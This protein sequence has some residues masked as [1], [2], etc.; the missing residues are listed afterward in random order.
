MCYK[1][2]YCV[3]HDEQLWQLPEA[4]QTTSITTC[5]TIIRKLYDQIKTNQTTKPSAPT[6]SATTAVSKIAGSSTQPIMPTSQAT[7][8]TVGI[9][10][11]STSHSIGSPSIWAKAMQ[12]KCKMKEQGSEVGAK[13][14][15]VQKL[16]TKYGKPTQEEF[17]PGK[18][19]VLIKRSGQQSV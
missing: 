14:S 13:M 1:C 7:P 6:F 11:I 19:D 9:Q 12:Y 8:G 10:T 18:N 15:R 5:G 16:P 4:T 3:K 17:L 2:R